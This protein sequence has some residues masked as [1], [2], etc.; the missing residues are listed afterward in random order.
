M[1]SG[2]ING[3]LFNGL[4]QLGTNMQNAKDTVTGN[5]NQGRANFINQTMAGN[6][7]LDPIYE[8]A[9][10]AKNSGWTKN[11]ALGAGLN[12]IVNNKD[13]LSNAA[14]NNTN[15]NLTDSWGQAPT[16]SSPSS[17]SS[18]LSYMYNGAGSGYGSNAAEQNFLDSYQKSLSPNTNYNINAQQNKGLTNAPQ[19]GAL[20]SPSL[21]AAVTK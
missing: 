19:A 16:P 10:T 13:S 21:G 8:V 1:G 5:I 11:G 20:K 2:P 12:D 4:Q 18:P 7:Y 6:D 3:S 9:N 14:V 17:S 15:S